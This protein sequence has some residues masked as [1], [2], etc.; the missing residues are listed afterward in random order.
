MERENLDPGIKRWVEIL[1]GQGVMTF[2]SCEGGEGHSF[3]E[4]TIRFHGNAAEGF[5]ALTHAMDW[6]MPVRDLRMVWDI[7]EGLPNGP[8]WEMTFKKTDVGAGKV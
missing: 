4:P 2:E 5:R 7:T 6:G 3:P 1:N 8:E